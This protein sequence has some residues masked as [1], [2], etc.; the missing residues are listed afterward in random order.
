MKKKIILVASATLLLLACQKTNSYQIEG[1]VAGENNLNGKWIYLSE[2][3]EREWKDID[4]VQ[5]E[6]NSFKFTGQADSAKIVYLMYTS[7]NGENYVTPFVLE[8]GKIEAGIDMT[9]AINIVGTSN[10]DILNGYISEKRQYNDEMM[11]IQREAVVA[12]VTNF[13][14]IQN[15]LQTLQ[16]K[17]IELDK[18]YSNNYVN[19]IIGNYVFTNSFYYFTVEEKEKLF[20]KMD[21]KTKANKQIAKIIDFT[22]NEKK[23]V[24]GQPYIDFELNDVNDEAKKVSD[25]V[26]NTDYL[27]IDFWASWCGPCLKS[28]PGLTEF[29]AKNKG[30]KFDI[31]GVSLDREKAQWVAAI[32]KYNLKWHHLSDLQ[33]WESK[34]AKIYA[35]NSIPATVL[36][37]RNGKIVGRNLEL[38]ELQKLINQPVKD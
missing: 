22:E 29:Y 27:L 31:V 15:I 4:S 18:K 21:D 5:V 38:T 8:N 16:D 30:A 34:A 36:I 17:N 35:V 10:N 28:F 25:F 26:G 13:D 14:S 3:V 12:N 19:T 9:N 6:E 20:A 7:D 2:N 32:Q 23:T 37:D 24:V 33:A 1:S 11:K